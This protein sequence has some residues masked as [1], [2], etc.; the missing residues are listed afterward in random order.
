MPLA[1]E[2]LPWGM[3]DWNAFENIM[4]HLFLNATTLLKGTLWAAYVNFIISKQA[5]LLIYPNPN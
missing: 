1:A 3:T 5:V 4:K 2:K